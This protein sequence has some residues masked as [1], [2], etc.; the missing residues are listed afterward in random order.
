M[1]GLDFIY[2][3]GIN[4]ELDHT[5]EDY[6]QGLEWAFVRF[7]TPRYFDA[8]WTESQDTTLRG[9]GW[10][11]FQDSMWVSIYDPTGLFASHVDYNGS[12]TGFSVAFTVPAT[13]TWGPGVVQFPDDV[14]FFFAELGYP[15]MPK[16]IVWPL[17]PPDVTSEP[18][19]FGWFGRAV[20]GVTGFVGDRIAII[21][22]NIRNSYI[23]DIIAYS[24]SGVVEA[25]A[26]ITEFTW[27]L[28][29]TDDE[30]QQVM[31][32]KALDSL[33]DWMRTEEGVETTWYVALLGTGLYGIAKSAPALSA[34]LGLKAP[35][36][37]AAL[38]AGGTQLGRIGLKDTMKAAR[39][40]LPFLSEAEGEEFFEETSQNPELQEELE[41]YRDYVA[42]TDNATLIFGAGGLPPRYKRKKE[43]NIETASTEEPA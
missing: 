41:G 19:S 7:G 23:D 27:N 32:A 21:D 35:W 30:Q 24:A 34:K 20:G 1:T 8:N 31:A 39:D 40:T 36:L 15:V 38:G 43:E 14:D 4:P 37:A 42:T 29:D 25:G 17:P 22:E 13:W 6:M 28:F 33:G 10:I 5:T 3:N 9:N 11:E 2:I 12:Q 16:P 26:D 18:E